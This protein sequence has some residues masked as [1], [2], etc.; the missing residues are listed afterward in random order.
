[1]KTLVLHIGMPKTGTTTLQRDYFP[2][3]E[4]YVGK[5]YD[6]VSGRSIGYSAPLF[7]K[8]YETFTRFTSEQPSD[9]R[10]SSIEKDL[11]DWV[12][13]IAVHPSK[14]FLF[15]DENF[16]RWPSLPGSRDVWPV[17]ESDGIQ[18]SGEL[19]LVSFLKVLKPIA[20]PHILIRTVVGIRNHTDFLFSFANQL[21]VGEKHGFWRE[22]ID[23]NAAYLNWS[24]HIQ[25]LQSLLGPENQLTLVF[26]DGLEESTA[27][28]NKYLQLDPNKPTPH[29]L[30]RQNKRQSAGGKW[31]STHKR[32]SLTENALFRSIA[33]RWHLKIGWLKTGVARFIW[34]VELSFGKSR[35]TTAVTPDER[36]A[37]QA[38]A[39]E[40]RVRLE[41]MLQKDLAKLGY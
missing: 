10:N 31:E 20:E 18:R 17:Q 6:P 28:I 33:S 9:V 24:G 38:W 36:S 22:V 27:L 23:R 15:S 29:P 34:L 16:A 26:E 40:D 35:F 3:L 21:G 11:E 4:E 13:E 2:H 30:G 37:I 19:P 12:K 25:S 14:T 7:S 39:R 32:V 5:F 8:L 1:M 41:K